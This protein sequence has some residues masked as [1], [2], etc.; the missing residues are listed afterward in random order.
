MIETYIRHDKKDKHVHRGDVLPGLWKVETPCVTPP[1]ITPGPKTGGGPVA[2]PNCLTSPMPMQMAAT[3]PLPHPIAFGS[4]TLMQAVDCFP[5]DASAYTNENFAR[6]SRAPWVG[7]DYGWAEQDADGQ[8]TQRRNAAKWNPGGKPSSDGGTIRV[9]AGIAPDC[10]GS[11]VDWE[12]PRQGGA[13]YRT[14]I[15]HPNVTDG[16]GRPQPV[17]AADGTLLGVVDGF[18]RRIETDA[19]GNRTQISGVVDS[20]G[21]TGDATGGIYRQRF[22][23]RWNQGEPTTIPI[24]LDNSIIPPNAYDVFLLDTLSSTLTDVST[25]GV[26][27]GDEI[28]IRPHP[29]SGTIT[30]AESGNIQLGGGGPQSITG[31]DCLTLTYYATHAKWVETGRDIH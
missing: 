30:V 7:A 10:R 28:R 27:P 3:A 18:Y 14:D 1:V 6:I 2:D 21:N 11:Y 20:D 15:T 31:Y 17:R 25:D 9:P 4:Q 22:E 24:L 29:S 12:T 16:Y 23:G 8:F 13:Y 26:T 19:D 5:M